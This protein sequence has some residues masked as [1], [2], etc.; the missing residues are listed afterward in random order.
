[1]SC[2]S[3]TEALDN[4]QPSKYVFVTCNDANSVSMISVDDLKTVKY[5]TGSDIGVETYE[6]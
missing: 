5:L 2:K 4:P 6:P 3:T 1:M